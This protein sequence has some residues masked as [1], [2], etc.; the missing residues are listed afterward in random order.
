MKEKNGMTGAAPEIME[1]DAVNDLVVRSY[2][3]GGRRIHG[4]PPVYLVSPG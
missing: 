3:S 2:L 1:L 4:T